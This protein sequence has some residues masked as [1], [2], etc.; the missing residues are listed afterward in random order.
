MHLYLI[1]ASNCICISLETNNADHAKVRAYKLAHSKETKMCIDYHLHK[2]TTCDRPS[3]TYRMD[4]Q[5]ERIVRA[6]S[7]TGASRNRISFTPVF[8][9]RTLL[10]M[11]SSSFTASATLIFPEFETSRVA[12]MKRCA[13]RRIPR[14][15]LDFE[16]TLEDN[17]DV[18][19]SADIVFDMDS[20]RSGSTLWSVSSNRDPIRSPN[21]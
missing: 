12:S 15:S 16:D 9:A 13:P 5:I 3:R 10:V 20:K 21:A 14:I 7:S 19:I 6:Q 1:L 2:M 18:P 11:A 17:D 8:W 4:Q